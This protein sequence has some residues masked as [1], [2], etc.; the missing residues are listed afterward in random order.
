MNQPDRRP[1]ELWK[2]FGCLVEDEYGDDSAG[3]LCD[4]VLILN[5]LKLGTRKPGMKNKVAR[6][7]RILEP[8]MRNPQAERE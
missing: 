3:A 2:H 1:W 7:F 8:M 4:L 6:I 5:E